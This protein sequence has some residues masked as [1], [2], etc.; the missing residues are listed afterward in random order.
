MLEVGDHTRTRRCLRS[1]LGPRLLSQKRP[2]LFLT[3]NR[4]FPSRDPTRLPS[5]LVICRSG[6]PSGP[7]TP[8]SSC[9]PGI[10]TPLSGSVLAPGRHSSLL[11]CI[12]APCPTGL[13]STSCFSARHCSTWAGGTKFRHLA[14]CLLEACP[15]VGESGVSC[16]CSL[17]YLR[18]PAWIPHSGSDLS[19]QLP[20]D[21]GASL[22]EL[23]RRT[24]RTCQAKS[25]HWP[26]TPA[27]YLPGSFPG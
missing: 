27:Y 11:T 3:R 7:G 6:L 4:G 13:P 5:L 2:F 23:V 16:S 26:E 12:S 20:G 24:G 8:S 10:I 22:W 14:L 18:P 1:E 17:L 25:Q 19:L 21:L 9:S 15:L